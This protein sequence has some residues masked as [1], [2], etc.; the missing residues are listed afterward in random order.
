[1]QLEDTIKEVESE[2]ECNICDY[3]TVS[4]TFSSQTQFGWLGFMIADL[5]K[6]WW[7]K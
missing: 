6:L 2:V 7:K 4:Y 1:M 5:A 3:I